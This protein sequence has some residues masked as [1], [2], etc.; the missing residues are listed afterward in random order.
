MLGCTMVSTEHSLLI[1]YSFVTNLILFVAV[2]V[3]W[4]KAWAR[5]RRWTEEVLLLREE[6]RRVSASHEHRAKWW[7]ERRDGLG[8][9]WPSVG[10]AEGAHAYASEQV[11]M[12]DDLMAQCKQVSGQECKQPVVLAT[13]QTSDVATDDFNADSDNGEDSSKDGSE[14]SSEDEDVVE[15]IEDL[16]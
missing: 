2:R 12:Y 9:E 4:C 7:R 13:P 15:D 14:D 3:E 6:L 8:C 11:A 1:F 16:S 5:A 10:H